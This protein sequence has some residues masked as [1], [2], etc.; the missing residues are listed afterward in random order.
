MHQ[1]E[2]NFEV[3]KVGL[4]WNSLKQKHT[5]GGFSKSYLSSGFLNVLCFMEAKSL[6]VV[7]H[8]LKPSTSKF[9]PLEGLNQTSFPLGSR[10]R[11]TNFNAISWA[12]DCT[13]VKS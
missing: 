6:G 10:G 1:Q 3:L 7:S 13:M 4:K 2:S 5:E 12:F 9:I 11:D 8:N